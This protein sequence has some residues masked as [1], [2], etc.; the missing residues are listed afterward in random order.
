MFSLNRFALSFV[1][2]FLTGTVQASISGN[3]EPSDPS[4]WT[5]ETDCYIGHTAD[6]SM[7]PYE[8]IVS[9]LSY[10]AYDAGVVGEARILIGDNWTNDDLYV[11]HDGNG[12]LYLMGTMD[13]TN[14]FIGF[15]AGSEGY[16][17][18]SGNWTNDSLYVGYGGNGSMSV[19][20]GTVNS[21]NGV[22]GVTP[23]A[24]GNV[25][26]GDHFC[27]TWNCDNLIVGDYGTGHLSISGGSQVFSTSSTVGENSESLSSVSIHYENARWTNS[28]DLSIG[29][30][31]KVEITNSGLLS[32][33][34]TLAIDSGCIEMSY[35]GKLALAGEADDSITDFLNL[36]EGDG[37]ILCCDNINREWKDIT[38]ATEG[39][40]YNLTY[41]T[42]GDLAGYTLLEVISGPLPMPFPW[43]GDANLDGRVD[44]SDVTILA[45]NWQYGVGSP[46]KDWS[47]GDFNGDGKVDGSDVTILAMNWQYGVPTSV[48][49]VPEPSC[50][51]LLV[52]A[53]ATGGVFY[54]SRGTC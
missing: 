40:E 46:P 34:G 49:A 39:V 50:L 29:E 48:N 30:N 44:G 13:S 54:R 14:G 37:S 4:T 47:D 2:L 3:V 17:S 11:G 22:I 42:T 33:G 10:I 41:L 19:I 36:V 45:D 28:N 35:N 27:A 7:M 20:G 26:I 25:L 15:A 21:V 18:V 52:I 5:S 24:E 9:H 38:T 23:G 32:V 53:F 31:G 8:S 43:P 12:S 1:F 16:A 6:G 51:I